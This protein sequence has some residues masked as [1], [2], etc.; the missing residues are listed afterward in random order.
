[1]N[2]YRELSDEVSDLIQRIQR[3]APPR[4]EPA[5]SATEFLLQSLSGTSGSITYYIN[6]PTSPLTPAPWN[7][8]S[9]PG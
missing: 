5:P 2:S 6:T 3:L 7:V 4:P 9:L 8:E 1:M